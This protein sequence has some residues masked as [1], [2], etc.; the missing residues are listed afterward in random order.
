MAAKAELKGKLSLDTSNFSKGIRAAKMG[1]E[2]LGKK[3]TSMSKAGL[4][5]IAAAATAAGVALAIGVKHAYDLG[6]ELQDMADKTGIAA[7]QIM[8]LQQAAKDN[9]IEDITGAVSKMQANLVEAVKK[10]AGPAAEALSELGLSADDLINKLPV[11]QLDAIGAALNK[12]GNSA[13]KAAEARAIFGKSGADLLPLFADAGAMETA[14]RSIGKQ[15][16]ILRDSAQRF[17]AVSDRLGRA[18]LKLQGFFVGVAAGVLPQ[19]EAATKRLDTLDL[20][21]KGVEFGKSLGEAADKLMAAFE[22]GKSMADIFGPMAKEA[23]K[24]TKDVGAGIIDG[25]L[26]PLKGLAGMLPIA[27]MVGHLSSSAAGMVSKA[28]TAKQALDL[29]HQVRMASTAEYKGQAP[30]AIA[31]PW[32]GMSSSLSSGGLRAGGLANSAG[33]FESQATGF[34]RNGMNGGFGSSS[35]LSRGAYNQT[36]LLSHREKLAAMNASVAMGSLQRDAR[37]SAAGAHDVIHSGDRA[38]AKAI[39]KQEEQKKLTLEG[40]NERLDK[41][42]V[43]LETKSGVSKQ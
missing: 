3:V 18:G 26:S 10:G 30:A 20:S 12:V 23:A 6:S 4:V 41:I 32:R 35:S 25:F 13:V 21:G 27:G 43:L 19:M 34:T 36:G 24:D 17:D 28:N 40:T 29:A 22:Y 33:Y 8:I 7:D 1:A 15:A 9:G 39:A 37:R 14:S 2:A 31:K 11:E 38:R 42:A 16:Q 5:G